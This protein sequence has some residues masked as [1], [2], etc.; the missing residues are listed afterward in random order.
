[1]ERL[2]YLR[3]VY[4]TRLDPT[5]LALIDALPLGRLRGWE[6]VALDV[7]EALDRDVDRRSLYSTLKRL[8][9][10]APEVHIETHYKL[11]L[12][13]LYAPHLGGM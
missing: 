13:L 6:D 3:E 8:R 5:S 12:R 1:M 4:G 9:R 7:G 2:L 10:A 11:G